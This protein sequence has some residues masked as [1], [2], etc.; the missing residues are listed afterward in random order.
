MVSATI[1]KH[2]PCPVGCG[3]YGISAPAIVTCVHS[4]L[5]MAGAKDRCHSCVNGYSQDSRRES[6]RERAVECM[7]MR[8]VALIFL[9]AE[10]T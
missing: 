10:A 9:S 1:C 2:D 3:V 8:G 4:V 7:F 5:T 6:D